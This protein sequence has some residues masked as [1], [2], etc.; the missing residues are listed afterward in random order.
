MVNIQ[1][2]KKQ[3]QK[4]NHIDSYKLFRYV[5]VGDNVNQ[6]DNICEVQ[7]DK[8][9]ATITSRFDGKISK[10]HYKIDDIALVGQPLVDIDVEE[11]SSSESSDSGKK[12]HISIIFVLHKCKIEKIFRIER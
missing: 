2:T 8:A 4:I 6:F 5:K 7:S 12:I 10:L 3:K 9:S 11:E 1:C